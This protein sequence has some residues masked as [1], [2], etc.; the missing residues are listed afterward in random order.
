M[1]VENLG[2]GANHA[3]RGHRDDTRRTGVQPSSLIDDLGKTSDDLM[4]K[5]KDR[6]VRALELDKAHPRQLG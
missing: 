3:F 1:G 2:Y 4:A 6:T 5:I